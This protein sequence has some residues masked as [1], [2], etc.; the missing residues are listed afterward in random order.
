M[1]EQN[2]SYSSVD[3]QSAPQTAEFS[4]KEF[5]S[6]TSEKIYSRRW[7]TLVI[8][9]SIQLLFV[10]DQTIVNVALPSI[11]SSLEATS[12]QLTWV[13]NGYLVMAGGLLLLG[14]RL[15]DILGRQRMFTAGVFAF[16][17]GSIVCGMAPNG[18]VLI[19]GRFF[20]GVGEAL[21]APAALALIALLFT[22]PDERA[23][24]FGIWGGISGIGSTLGVLLSGILVQFV[25]WRLIFLINIPI[26]VVILILLPRY[27][28]NKRAQSDTAVTKKPR[29][30]WVGAV[31]DSWP[32]EFF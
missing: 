15:G 17:A 32:P 29:I 14:G 3:K 7:F 6:S 31:I 12:N 19:A 26:I 22:D 5:P 10:L 18:N 20:Q 1:S 11:E 25:G 4:G 8:L 27:V 2:N 24:A 28:M 23:K 16:L 13:V 30:D 9:S 21:A